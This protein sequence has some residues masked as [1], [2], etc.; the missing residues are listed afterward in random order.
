M[1]W[2]RAHQRQERGGEREKAGRRRRG[3]AGRRAGSPAP[4][5]SPQT[6]ARGAVR[7]RRAPVGDH[8]VGP[9]LGPRLLR[10]QR[11]ARRARSVPTG[12]CSR[13][14]QR[15]AFAQRQGLTVRRLSVATRLS[16]GVLASCQRACTALES[17][18]DEILT[19]CK[20]QC[21]PNVAPSASWR[22]I[23]TCRISQ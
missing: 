4:L 17:S 23:S 15:A 1:P 16:E 8:A 19:R 6:L 7:W 10:T 18:A 21:Q 5:T 11:S 2:P 20:G 12:P 14:G 13:L 22:Q 9:G 3:G